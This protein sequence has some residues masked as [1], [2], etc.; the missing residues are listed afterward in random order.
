MS[1]PLGGGTHWYA[2]GAIRLQ[3]KVKM[4]HVNFRSA[5]PQ[6][7]RIFGGT[8]S[9]S[10]PPPLPPRVQFNN[11]APVGPGAYGS[12]SM[13]NYYG[14]G[15]GGYGSG[16][17]GGY[18]GGF[19]GTGMFNSFGYGSA[20]MYGNRYGAGGGGMGHYSGPGDVE[21]RFIQMAEENSRPA[22]QSI[23]SFVSVIGNFASMLDSTF[24]ALSNSFRA[25]LGVTAN[26]GKL[27]S[28]FGQFLS[29]IAL[30]RGLHWLWRK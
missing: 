18:S 19:G 1:S 2:A 29:S 11:N 5:L 30:F 10:A 3:N 8:T 13:P 9:I 4:D 16:G 14:Y 6:E 23:E 27:R 22:F 17:Y 26:L 25:I 20:G 7:N 12:S 28:M 24:F 15:G 21:S